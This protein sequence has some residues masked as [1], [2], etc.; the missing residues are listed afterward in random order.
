MTVSEVAALAI[1]VVG[2]VSVFGVLGL[3]AFSWW[4]EICTSREF[5]RRKR[6]NK[7]QNRK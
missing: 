5:A 4:C 6:R 1:A 7:E 3:L 2:G